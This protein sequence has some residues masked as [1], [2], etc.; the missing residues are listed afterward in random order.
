[1]LENKFYAAHRK[2]SSSPNPIT[3]LAKPEVQQAQQN[4][5][6]QAIKLQKKYPQVTQEEM[7]SLIEKFKYA[8]SSL[9]VATSG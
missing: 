3:T 8:S 5:R 2:T 4:P 9:K 7:F 1:L 6:M